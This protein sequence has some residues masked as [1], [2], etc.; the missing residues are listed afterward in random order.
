MELEDAVIDRL[1]FGPA[2]CNGV[3]RWVNKKGIDATTP[4]VAHVLGEL[5]GKGK[6]TTECQVNKTDEGVS[7]K[8]LKVYRLVL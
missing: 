5:I 7:K 6:V 4:Q 1:L 3:L 8:Y 2:T